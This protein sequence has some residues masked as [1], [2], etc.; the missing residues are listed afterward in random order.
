M[1]FHLNR[2]TLN[3]GCKR[4]GLL[5][6][7]VATLAGCGAATAENAV[8]APTARTDV[9]DP[10]V[11]NATPIP[12][13]QTFTIASSKHTTEPVDYPQDPPVG[14]PHDPSWQRCGVYDAPVKPEHAV[15]SME[16]GAVWITYR[17]D[18]AAA[19]V[20][21]LKSVVAGKRY[22]LVSPY[23][24]LTDPIVASAWGAQLRLADPRDPRLTE[25]LDRYAG[26]GPESGANCDIGVELTVAS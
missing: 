20:E 25:F 5:L 11:A 21:F 9:F 4:A 3:A 16:H 19:D 24:G 14:G 15:H 18:L 6:T 23:P 17:P 12:G 7:L 22:L 10:E 8:V 26:R 13:V 1:R 2:A